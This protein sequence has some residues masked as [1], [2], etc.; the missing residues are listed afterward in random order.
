MTAR[1][2]SEPRL[3]EDGGEPEPI[4]EVAASG[5]YDEVL[6]SEEEQF[7][8]AFVDYWIR[9]GSEIMGVVS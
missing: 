1:E 3:A 8:A 5:T 6:S 4:L 7:V 2:D 9:R